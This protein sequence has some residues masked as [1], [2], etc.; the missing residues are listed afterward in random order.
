VAHA[1]WKGSISFGLVEIPVGLY[2]AE[3]SDELRFHLV[4]RRN[5][6]PV[7]YQRINKDTGQPVS[8][9]DIVRGYELDD[10]RFVILSDD[11]FK[12]A[13]VDATETVD[14]V[15]FVDGREIDPMFYERPY[16]LAPL[17]RGGKAYALLRETL[18]RTGRVGIARVVI[19]TRQ[20]VAALGVRHQALVL[21][22]LR[23]GH[24]LRDP[25]GL[26][27]P[28]DDAIRSIGSKE[29]QLAEQLVEAMFGHF[30]PSA[31]RDQY[32]DDLLALIEHKADTG[33]T[34]EYRSRQKEKVE[35]VADIMALLK[36]SVHSAPANQDRERA[37]AGSG[38]AE[39]RPPRQH[40]AR[41]SRTRG[42]GGTASR[43]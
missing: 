2:A 13:N 32:R 12:K 15:Q 22:L 24:E 23:Y 6:A 5:H 42:N 35:G 27:L 26:D 36:K 39:R 43:K 20:Y 3:S 21:N 14:I 8:W 34:L 40:Q 7:G 41:S 25:S 4:D 38:A 29:L 33:V 16:Y 28:G 1:I 19:R 37:S 10:G 11:D 17:S 18:E 31:F 9:D 30:D